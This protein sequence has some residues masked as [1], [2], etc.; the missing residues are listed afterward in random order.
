MKFKFSALILAAGF[1]KRLRP[2]TYKIPKCLVEV[3]GKPII[4]YWLD[5][6]HSIGCEEVLI[7]THYLSVIVQKYIS[8]LKYKNMS[9]HITYEEELLGTAKT[10]I[11]NRNFFE[12]KEVL[13]MHADNYSSVNLSELIKAHVNRSEYT[14]A[15]ML[16][17][18]TKDPS[19][20]GIITKDKNGV[21]T[22]FYEKVSDP[23]SNCANGAIYVLSREFMKWHL[24]HRKDAVDFSLDVLPHLNG[25]MQTWHTDLPYI[26][27]GTPES[28]KKANL[29]NDQLLN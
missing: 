10:L 12:N 25:R 8:N 23:P 14:L 28:L 3:G 27:I 9:V 21:M 5:H 20:C 19:K 15:T 4:K 18:N 7:N 17:F 29:I 24:D 6:L 2:I 26:D 1:G 13:L 22:S 16:T 11:N